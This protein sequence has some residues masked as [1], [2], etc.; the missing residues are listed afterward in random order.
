[1]RRRDCPIPLRIGYY[2]TSDCSVTWRTRLRY[3]RIWLSAQ[4]EVGVDQ[5][6]RAARSTDRH[7]VCM[8]GPKAGVPNRARPDAP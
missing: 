8:P 5:M 6:R 2:S 1:M 4:L 7:R 3:N